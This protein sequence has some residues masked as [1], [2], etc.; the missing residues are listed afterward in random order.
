MRRRSLV[1]LISDFLRDDSYADALLLA[2]ALSRN[3]SVLGVWLPGVALLILV[4]IFAPAAYFLNRTLAEHGLGQEASSELQEWL[5]HQ[6]LHSA[7]KK[8]AGIVGFLA[9]KTRP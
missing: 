7:P 6:I 3:G 8:I 4:A 2:R 1:F 9:R 5:N